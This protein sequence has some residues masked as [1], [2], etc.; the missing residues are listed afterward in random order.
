MK[1]YPHLS[2]SIGKVIEILRIERGMSKSALADYADI[3]RCYLLEILNGKKNPTMNVVYSI[4][5]ALQI[6]PV[7]FVCM[8]N[9]EIKKLENS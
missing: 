9:E 8:V 6:D 3:Q 1:N 7:E 5:E 2:K 4:C